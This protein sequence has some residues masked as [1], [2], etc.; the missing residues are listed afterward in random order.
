[1][2]NKYHLKNLVCKR[3]KHQ[4]VAFSVDDYGTQRTA[5]FTARKNLLKIRNQPFINRF[6]MY[7]SLENTED[8]EMLFDTLAS[9]KDING[10]HAIFTPFALSANPDFDTMIQNGFSEYIYETLPETYQK[11]HGNQKTLKMI[12]EGIEKQIF[13]PQ[14][15][16]REHMNIKVMMQLLSIRDPYTVA[17]FKNNSYSGIVSPIKNIS[18]MGSFGFEDFS[19]N[20]ELGII[21]I[22]GLRLFE[23]T[24][25]Y[26]AVHFTAPGVRENEIIASYLFNKGIKYID[27]SHF[28]KPYL[29]HGSYG[30]T[31]FHYTGAGNRYGQKYIVRNCVFEPSNNR[32]FDSVAHCMK[33][34]DAAFTMQTVANISS[35]RVN[36]SGN[37]ETENRAFGLGELKRLLKTIV[38]KFPGVEFISTPQ[39][40]NN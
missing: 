14:F 15:H 9:V 29:G 39:I 22:D 38:K 30:M 4:M 5:S 7:D 10:H 40:L 18:P 1:M 34:I 33:L 17:C 16:G 6:D 31:S 25:G 19:E 11:M 21:A 8:L 3:T 2:L 36:F 13:I 27:R 12:K 23:Q 26:K 37:I 28:E 20:Q 24:Y 32:S 35:H